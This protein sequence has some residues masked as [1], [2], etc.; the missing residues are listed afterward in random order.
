M[1]KLLLVLA[2][3]ITG[4]SDSMYA[5]DVDFGVKV[6]LNLANVVG[7]DEDRNSLLSFHIGGLAEITFSDKFSLQ[8]EL[9][10]SRQGFEA[11]EAEAKFKL[12]YLAI[13]IM[14]KYYL[15]EK[16]SVEIGPQA[17][18]LINDKVVF[19]DSD[20]PDADTD[21]SSF[22]LGLNLGIGLNLNSNLLAQI[23]YSYGITTVAENP[24]VN[25]SVLQVSLGYKF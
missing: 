25:N 22:D 6:G 8:P 11:K 24:D 2:I 3:V 14:A 15:G 5:Q 16:F 10:Y 9:L 17:S 23:R 18:F 7:D 13:P 1:K 12:D 20:I 19:D 21:A 4:L